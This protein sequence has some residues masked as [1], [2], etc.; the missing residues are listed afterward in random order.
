MSGVVKTVKNHAVI[1]TLPQWTA[2]Q[3]R[4]LLASC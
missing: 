1:K 2:P 4:R 3:R